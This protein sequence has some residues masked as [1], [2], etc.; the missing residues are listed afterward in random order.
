MTLTNKYHLGVVSAR[1][2]GN[3]AGTISSGSNDAGGVSYGTYQLSSAKGTLT[4]YLEQSRFQNQFAGLT[5]AT[6]TFDAK[7]RELASSDPA[8]AWDQQDFIR[9]TH[10]DVQLA[11]LKHAGIDLADR[12]QA[13]QEAVFSTS[14]QFGNLTIPVFTHGLQAAFGSGY[15][16]SEL[17]DR[18]IVTAV[19]DYK[20]EHI[21]QL[22]SSSGNRNSLLHRAQ[23]EKA[24]L[25]AIADG[26]QLPDLHPSMPQTRPVLKQGNHGAEVAKL[27]RNLGEMG[28]TLRP[29]GNFGVA[30][31]AAVESFQRAHELTPDGIAG[32][33]T[34]AALAQASREIAGNRA[35]ASVQHPLC[36]DHPSHPDHALYLQAHSRVCELDL[37][38]GRIPDQFTRNLA[39]ALVVS[40]R[41]GGLAQI[42]RVGLGENGSVV[43]GV[44]RLSG[45]NVSAE[46]YCRVDALRSLNTPMAQ[47]ADQWSGAMQECTRQQQGSVARGH[48]PAPGALLAIHER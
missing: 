29:D 40:A 13:V 16:L 20:I 35:G 15:R 24:D 41:K 26:E 46:K 48:L 30:T 32:P 25:V 10:Y 43:W 5:P 4:A 3:G 18:D 27:Q 12:G 34:F 23:A 19:Q 28:Y 36:L 31:Q 38:H 14:V 42:D 8:F 39:S 21:D 7:W 6:P 1:H 17:S 37:Q 47:S 22:F 44:Q 45:S 2:E 9:T 11:R 33:A